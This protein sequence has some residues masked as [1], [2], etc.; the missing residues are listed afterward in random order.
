MI[1]LELT[2]RERDLY[3]EPVVVNGPSENDSSERNA[4]RQGELFSV[5]L[6][7]QHRDE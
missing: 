3:E 7:V 4:Q 2:R 5:P 6:P 1:R